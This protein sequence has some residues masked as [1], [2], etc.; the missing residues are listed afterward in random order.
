MD[1]WV[2]PG[3]KELIAKGEIV[4]NP[5]AFGSNSY[6]GTC[7]G[8]TIRLEDAGTVTIWEEENNAAVFF[9]GVPYSDDPYDIDIQNLQTLANTKCLA[10]IQTSSLMGIV[11]LVELKKT[12]NML[13]HPLSSMNDLL[14]YL[15]QLRQAKQNIKV[16]WLGGEHRRINGRDFHYRPKRHRGPGHVVKPPKSFVIPFGD[17]ISGSVLANNLG[18]R[19]MLM[20]LDAI[21]RDIPQSHQLARQ[22]FRAT[23]KDEIHF[24]KTE[25]ASIAEFL[26]GTWSKKTTHSLKVRSSCIVEDKFDVLAD[27]GMSLADI[28]GAA[29]ELIPYSFLFDYVVNVGDV[30]AAL[31]ALTTRNILAFSTTTTVDTV[32]E[33]TLVANHFGVG[34]K[35][36]FVTEPQATQK[37][38]LKSK[39]RTVGVP[40]VG[41]ALRPVAKMLT[42]SHIQNSLSLIV[43][44]LSGMSRGK[45]TPF[46]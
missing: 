37:L 1:D 16:E 10:S 21:L 2:T 24:N 32:V 22:T 44:Q 30:L 6:E 18:L 28:P 4:N 41:L 19:P 5:L 11:S 25:V 39:G 33:R 15:T 26:Y 40:G 38:S 46:Y 36:T 35:H 9:Y 17:A 43:Q 31:K 3:Y 45:K 14:G 13:L 42:P 27:F 23:E 8:C 34:V 29:W 20:D 7:S 12:F